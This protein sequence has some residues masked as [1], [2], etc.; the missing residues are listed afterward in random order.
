MALTKHGGIALAEIKA[1][2][3]DEAV[4]WADKLVEV[5]RRESEQ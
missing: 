5:M 2:P 3:P 4:W 1:M